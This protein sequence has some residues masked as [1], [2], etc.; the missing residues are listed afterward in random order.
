MEASTGTFAGVPLLG[1]GMNRMCHNHTV[2]Y[3]ATLKADTLE[4]PASVWVTP[5]TQC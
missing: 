1:E 3:Y 4:L 5:Q 2:E